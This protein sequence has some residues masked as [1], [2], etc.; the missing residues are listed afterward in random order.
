MS[1]DVRRTGA[2]SRPHMKI[3]P[4][5]RIVEGE[6]TCSLISIEYQYLLP[7]LVGGEYR[8]RAGTG[9]VYFKVPGLYGGDRLKPTEI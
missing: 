8:P 4:E 1:Q 2:K 7:H 5:I 6:I 9:R 3:D